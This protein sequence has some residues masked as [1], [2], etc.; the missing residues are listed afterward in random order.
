MRVF[1]NDACGCVRF[2]ELKCVACV[3]FMWIK[4]ISLLVIRKTRQIV[5]P[6]EFNNTV[7]RSSSEV[8]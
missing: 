6:E 3:I 4:N 2:F 1:I 5:A 7:V 8:D